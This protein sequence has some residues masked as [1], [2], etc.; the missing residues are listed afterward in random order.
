MLVFFLLN[1]ARITQAEVL[2][3]NCHVKHSRPVAWDVDCSSRN[4][5]VLPKTLENQPI[6]NF[7]LRNNM[8]KN[9]SFSAWVNLKYLDISF[10]QV[11]AFHK[12]MLSGVKNLNFLNISY[13]TLRNIYPDNFEGLE[14]LKTLDISGNFLLKNEESVYQAINKTLYNGLRRLYAKSLGLS[15][16]PINIFD[17]ASELE[18][19]DLKYNNITFLPIFPPNLRVLDLSSNNLKELKMHP[20]HMATNLREL[21]IEDNKYLTTID[22]DAFRHT[23]HLERISLRGS[24]RLDYLPK[25][26]F[27]HL[28]L[29]SLSLARCNFTTLH[30][31][32]KHQFVQLEFLDLRGNPWECNASIRW[33]TRLDGPLAKEIRCF[34][35]R[36]VSIDSYFGMKMSHIVLGNLLALLMGLLL[37]FF[38]LGLWFALDLEKKSR[39]SHMYSP[40]EKNVVQ[41]RPVYVS[42]VC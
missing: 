23:K 21:I 1:L 8:F 6:V 5:Q 13:N 24:I 37:I 42:T 2:P 33:F 36:N 22:H 40:L 4:L 14:H 25:P 9:V 27:F 3:F 39:L 31:Y 19:L 11:N 7:T 34:T 30:P 17:H 28:P 38:G 32:F 12:S 10:N 20:F 41:T 15:D 35:P 16:F 18:I 29:K 26:L